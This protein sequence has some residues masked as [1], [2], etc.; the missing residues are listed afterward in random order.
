LEIERHDFH[1]PNDPAVSRGVA[2]SREKARRTVVGGRVEIGKHDSHFSTDPIACGA[3]KAID[4]GPLRGSSTIKKRRPS[5]RSRCSLLQAHS[6]MRK[7]SLCSYLWM[8]RYPRDLIGRIFAFKAFRTLR[9]F[10]NTTNGYQSV[11]VS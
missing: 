2:K 3:R 7:C 6:S 11:L 5:G 8:L 9:G 1:I 4:Y 10:T